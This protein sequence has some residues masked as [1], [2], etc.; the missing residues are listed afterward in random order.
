MKFSYF[1][2]LCVLLVFF[3]C[4]EGNDVNYDIAI[5]NGSVIN[6]ESGVIAKQDV[7]IKDNRIVE[8]IIFKINYGKNRY[9]TS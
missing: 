4:K 5:L 2:S 9:S 7:F 3:N 1:I 8:I 6:I